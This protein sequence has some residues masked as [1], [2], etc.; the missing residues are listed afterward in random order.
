MIQDSQHRFGYSLYFLV[1]PAGMAAGSSFAPEQI[2]GNEYAGYNCDLQWVA[3]G[4]SGGNRFNFLIQEFHQLVD[5]G[6]VFIGLDV[7]GR[8]QKAY[9]HGVPLR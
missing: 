7:K 5:I 2:V 8:T 3:A 4:R 6:R 1:I 9:S